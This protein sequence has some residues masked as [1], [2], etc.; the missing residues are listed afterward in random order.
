MSDKAARRFARSAIL[1]MGYGS[2]MPRKAKRRFKPLK[3]QSLIYKMFG[4][5]LYDMPLVKVR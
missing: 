3:H 4:E 1:G 2:E 5:R